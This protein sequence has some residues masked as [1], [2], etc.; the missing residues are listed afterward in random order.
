MPMTTRAAVAVLALGA[1]LATVLV[2]CGGDDDDERAGLT[3]TIDVEVDDTTT[4]TEP[5][6]TT[7]LSEADR[8]RT[9]A[10]ELW[11]A[12][13]DLYQNP[14]ADPEAAL[15]EIFDRQCD[16]FQ[17][18]LDDLRDLIAQSARFSGP[19]AMVLG[20][21]FGDFDAP[22]RVALVDLAFDASPRQLMSDQGTVLDDLSGS[23][24]FAVAIGLVERDGRWL[25]DV[26]VPL[27]VDASFVEDLI[28]EGL[29]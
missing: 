22:S 17:A 19:P 1:A 14:P 7:T 26:V 28:A 15:V 16:C 27:Q 8:F 18:E 21:R 12:R 11:T 6:T 24:P 5:A 13:N 3:T 2:G 23:E 29:P 9:L 4:T 20:A 25:I 10:V